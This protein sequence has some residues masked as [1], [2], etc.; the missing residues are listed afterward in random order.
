MNSLISE[1]VFWQNAIAIMKEGSWQGQNKRQ[2]NL[3]K[4][5]FLS[6]NLAWMKLI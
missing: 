3:K 4:A 5:H 6:Q 2:I 1:E